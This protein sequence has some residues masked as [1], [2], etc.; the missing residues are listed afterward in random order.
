MRKKIRM[1]WLQMN[2]KLPPRMQM[3]IDTMQ[4]KN[5]EQEAMKG[6]MIGQNNFTFNPSE[7]K[8]V[9]NF[10]ALHLQWERRLAA[11]KKTKKL[12]QVLG[13]GYT[14]RQPSEPT[15]HKSKK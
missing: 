6:E 2:S 7:P 4:R 10:K 12:T 8:S 3:H 13:L 9:P 11:S 15:F 14:Y 1:Q 5:L